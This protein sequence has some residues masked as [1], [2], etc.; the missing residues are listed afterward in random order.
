MLSH[1]AK[2]PVRANEDQATKLQPT[3]AYYTDRYLDVFHND[4]VVIVLAIGSKVRGFKLGLGRWLFKVDENPYHDFHRRGMK[5]P[6]PWLKI[7]RNVK[8]PCEV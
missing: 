4:L 8:N 1:K 6:A 3:L 7:L 5:P 2:N